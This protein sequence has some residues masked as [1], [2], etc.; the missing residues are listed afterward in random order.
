MKATRIIAKRKSICP[1]CYQNIFPGVPCQVYD[2]KWYHVECW[3]EMWDKIA[4][5]KDE[6]KIIKAKITDKYLEMEIK[7]EENAN[8]L[9]TIVLQIE[10][11]TGRVREIA[12]EMG[13][14]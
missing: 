4:E 7:Q 2:N 11:L 1:G 10:I 14:W 5:E 3:Q 8:E 9:R 13:S 12:K 6:N